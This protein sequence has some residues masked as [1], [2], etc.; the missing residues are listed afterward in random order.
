[1]PGTSCRHAAGTTVQ[2][3][4]RRRAGGVPAGCRMV[5]C[6]EWTMASLELWTHYQDMKNAGDYLLSINL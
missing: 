5:G 3:A 4:C 1:M 6:A 2:E